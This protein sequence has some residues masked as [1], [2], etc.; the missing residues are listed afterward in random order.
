[1]R[2]DDSYTETIH[3]NDIEKQL[4]EDNKDNSPEYMCHID[5][6]DMNYSHSQTLSSNS[7]VAYQFS[8]GLK[9]ASILS[10]FA[11]LALVLFN[12]YYVFFVLCTLWGYFASLSYRPWMVLTFFFYTIV[13][14]IVRISINIYDS[15]E[16][17]VNDDQ[18]YCFLNIIW[19][20]ILLSSSTYGLR[21]IWR[22][23]TKLHICTDEEKIQLRNIRTLNL[24]AL[25]W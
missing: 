9:Y 24:K 8:K 3:S 25:C 12:K 21:L 20:L 22:V 10:F 19:G 4:N 16:H 5:L 18:T 23:Y 17:Y 6:N 7:L 11:N 1:M 15:Y 2:V 13:N 14:M